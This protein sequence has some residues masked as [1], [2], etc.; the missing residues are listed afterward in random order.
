MLKTNCCNWFYLKILT[1]WLEKNSF[2]V[3][4]KDEFEWNLIQQVSIHHLIFDKIKCLNLRSSVKG[5]GITKRYRDSWEGRW[6]GTYHSHDQECKHN[7]PN[8]IWKVRVGREAYSLKNQSRGKRSMSHG[9]P[10]RQCADYAW[11]DYTIVTRR[12]V[13]GRRKV[14][15]GR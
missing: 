4:K 11:I 9:C 1:V 8:L 14:S 10:E 7:L 15:G 6:K 3:K 5:D 12:G 2:R 13:G